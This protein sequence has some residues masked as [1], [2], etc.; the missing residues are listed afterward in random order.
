MITPPV[1]VGFSFPV[2]P[3]HLTKPCHNLGG[4]TVV[5][6]HEAG[7]LIIGYKEVNL[8]EHG[9][10]EVRIMPV[11]TNHILM[12][13]RPSVPEEDRATSVHW[14]FEYEPDQIVYF[15]SFATS[16]WVFNNPQDA[17]GMAALIVDVK[18][19]ALLEYLNT[20]HPIG[21]SQPDEESCAE[22]DAC[23]SA[24]TE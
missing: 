18:R 19:H 24:P 22:E 1:P 8:F 5:E 11:D 17:F 15:V 20:M 16:T 7:I 12:N 6:D 14:A 3:K 4:Y 2:H 21:T 9:I 23:Q 10:S 13:K